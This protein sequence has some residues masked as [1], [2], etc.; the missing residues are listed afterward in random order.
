MAHPVKYDLSQHV[1]T[2]VEIRAYDKKISV[3]AAILQA[4]AYIAELSDR[5]ITD[6]KRKQLIASLTKIYPKTG[7][8]LERDI[9]AR[10]W[11]KRP[12]MPTL[13]TAQSAEDRPR[14]QAVSELR[15]L[16]ED[17]QHLAHHLELEDDPRLLSDARAFM[18]AIRT[19]LAKR[20]KRKTRG[21]KK[22]K[23]LR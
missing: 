14:Q 8:G 17:L 3:Q 10:R 5:A 12:V 7:P 4:I 23:M 1:R 18:A 9:A 21:A 15:A 2:V 13:L 19:A 16:L 22:K 11:P 20:D 6:T